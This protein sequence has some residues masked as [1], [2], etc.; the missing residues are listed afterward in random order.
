MVQGFTMNGEKAATY[1]L[2]G[3]QGLGRTWSMDGQFGQFEAPG[4][5]APPSAPSGPGT[6]LW[7]DPSLPPPPAPPS[8]E[9]FTLPPQGP[10]PV[11]TM[12]MPIP[13]QIPPPLPPGA[14]PMPLGAPQPP[15]NGNNRLLFVGLLGLALW[16]WHTQG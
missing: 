2:S 11:P 1:G 15:A 8:F 9:P 5:G 12:P 3:E 16:Y 7:E 6:S 13:P 14:N 4:L 10:P